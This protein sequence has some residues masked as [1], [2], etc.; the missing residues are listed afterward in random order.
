VKE[1]LLVKLYEKEDK[2]VACESSKHMPELLKKLHLNGIGGPR[3][4]LSSSYA[5]SEWIDVASQDERSWY[6]H[7]CYLKHSPIP[8]ISTTNTSGSGVS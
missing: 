8:I 6:V 3:K 1:A 5:V 7:D 2:G 4:L